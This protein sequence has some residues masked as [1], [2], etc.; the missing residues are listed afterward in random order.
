MV[1]KKILIKK[2][3]YSE[4]SRKVTETIWE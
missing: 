3:I 2:I 1:S 4:Y